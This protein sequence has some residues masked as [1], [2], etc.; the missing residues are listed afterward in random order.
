MLYIYYIIYITVNQRYA[1]R[2]HAPAAYVN[3]FNIVGL[4]R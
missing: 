4:L 1:S 3:Q 2:G